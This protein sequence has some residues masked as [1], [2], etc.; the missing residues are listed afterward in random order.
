MRTASIF[1]ALVRLTDV[2]GQ[3]LQHVYAIGQNK[4]SN[5][6]NLELALNN[7]VESLTRSCR[8]IVIRGSRLE[9]PGAAN[10]RLA[11]LTTR[12]LLQRME[13][14]T[15]KRM[16][17]YHEERITNRYMQARHTAEEILL[18]LQELQIEQLGGFWLPVAAFAF[19]ATVSFLLRCALETENS[20]ASLAQS[21]SFR[22][23][24]DLVTTLRSLQK[25][26][27]WDLADICLAQHSEIVDRI[28][29]DVATFEG[30]GNTMDGQEF[31]MPDASILDQYFP[32][33]WDPLQN[34]W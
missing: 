23:A 7:W 9:V 21:N 10:L 24:R 19:P 13:L 25:R 2:L 18:L 6:A 16:S 32:S 33:L 29:A 14:E 26:Y 20:L 17:V 31:V 30:G 22:I 34:S 12:L 28:L 8:L 11:Y 27:E 15:D 5:I 3:H 1:I 4:P